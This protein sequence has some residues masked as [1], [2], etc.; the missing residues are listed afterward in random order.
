MLVARTSRRSRIRSCICDTS[1]VRLPG[2]T[3]TVARKR[4][5][6]KERDCAQAASGPRVGPKAASGIMKSHSGGKSFDE[7]GPLRLAWGW[8]ARLVRRILFGKTVPRLLF[9]D[10]DPRRAETFLAE[11][12]HAVWVETVA[13]CVDRLRETWDEVHLDHDLGGRQLV[14]VDEVDCGMEVIRW[15]CKEP[16]EHLRS[17]RF[18]VHTH[19]LVAGLMMVLQMR[20]SGFNAEFRPFGEDLARILAHNEPDGDQLRQSGVRDQAVD[21][22]LSGTRLWRWLT[23]KA[24]RDPAVDRDPAEGA[25]PPLRQPENCQ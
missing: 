1:S 24:G 7:A 3:S 4:T 23:R 6:G 18:L 14:A 5:F 2:R 13:D 17:T 16:R 15:L 8:L 10:D 11:H 12:P 22:W 25:E 20:S 21:R 19:N 9:L